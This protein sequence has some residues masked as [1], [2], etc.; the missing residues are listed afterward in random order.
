M[1]ELTILGKY[2]LL[3]ATIAILVVAA[4]CGTT[5]VIKEVQV[6]GETIV[7]E[8]EVIKTIEVPGQTVT[9]E[10]IKEVRVPGETITVITEVVKEVR[11]P[12][13]TVIVTKEV[14]VE[15]DKIVEKL[16]RE[17][18]VATPGPVDTDF[19]ITALDPNYKRGGILRTA[20]N[21]PPSHWDFYVAG[22][23]TWHGVMQSMYDK[24]LRPDHRTPDMTLVPDIGTS[25]KT[26]DDMT[27][28]TF[29]I[30]DGVKFH[31]GTDLTG[32]D[33]KATFDRIAFPESYGEG[34]A[35]PEKVF[36]QTASLKEITATDSEVTFSLE[37][38]RSSRHMMAA[39][40]ASGAKIMS[41]ADLDANDGNMK[42]I[43][44]SK[45][46]GSGP[47]KF[48]E[49]NA[50]RFLVTANPDYWNPNAPYLDGIETIWI[51]IFSPEQ[52]AAIQ[53]G[54]ID[55]TIAPAQ[56]DI[57]KLQKT[58]G[59]QSAKMYNPFYWHVV[60]NS[61]RAPFNDARVRQAA[62]LVIDPGALAKV[63]NQRI[64]VKFSGGW[65][66][67]G[68]GLEQYGADVLATQKYFRPP[69]E[70]DIAEAKQLLSDAGYPNGEGMPVIDLPSRGNFA[71]VSELM[72]AQLLQ[73]LG[74]KSEVRVVDVGVWRE[75]KANGTFDIG[76][77]NA[78]YT[79]PVPEV[80]INNITG[81]CDGVPCN[82]NL[83]KFQ[84]TTLD[85]L[86]EKLRYAAQADRYDISVEIAD[87]LEKGMPYMPMT[88]M[89][90][91]PMY[92]HPQVKGFAANGSSWSGFFETLTRWDH[93][94]LDR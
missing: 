12:G 65:F 11:V 13:E 28:W 71:V 66:P 22:S 93:V 4:A 47:F 46:S 73:H 7:V 20:N 31:N 1:T 35:S 45:V 58:K 23:I 19:Y 56:A 52:T 8:K 16:V 78:L 68:L 32:H 82:G 54:M 10:V 79:V 89:G 50:D 63:M 38:A 55:W 81:T 21:G 2:K 90:Y 75:T 84:D 91:L 86:F 57:P 59:L 44:L 37:E 60:F 24:L 6:P 64:G 14:V 77:N 39:F 18:V 53:T 33:V 5:E 69:T 40:S 94:W 61:N 34:L 92:W 85:A 51:R 62:A 43:D 49:Q 74:L 70:E 30:R 67:E 42:K 48:V 9:T 3:A 17:V 72:Q 83:G 87:Q 25:W 80:F 27:Q 41:K 36:W 15:V 29:Q 26:N 76:L 88:S